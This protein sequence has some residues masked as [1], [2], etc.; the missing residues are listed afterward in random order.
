MSDTKRLTDAEVIRD[1]GLAEATMETVA[2]ATEAEEARK[3]LDAD[4]LQA[5]EGVRR[6][7]AELRGMAPFRWKGAGLW[8]WCPTERGQS[9]FNW[10]GEPTGRA[11]IVRNALLA[12]VAP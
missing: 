10:K 11:C 3:R 4:H 9:C 7:A 12:E 8:C 2:S 5:R 6:L 1:R